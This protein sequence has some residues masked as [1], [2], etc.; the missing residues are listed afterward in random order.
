MGPIDKDALV[1]VDH[2]GGMVAARSLYFLFPEEGLQKTME[3]R[4][5]AMVGEPLN[6][7]SQVAFLCRGSDNAARRKKSEIIVQRRKNAVKGV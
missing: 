4:P 6:H 2:S 1:F 7:G 3:A 5:Q